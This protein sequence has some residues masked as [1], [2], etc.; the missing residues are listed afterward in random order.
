MASYH[1]ELKSDKK[2]SGVS[3]KAG[4][5]IS[6]INREGKFQNIDANT[7]LRADVHSYRSTISGTHPILPLPHQPVLLY[8]SPFGKIKLDAQGIH[9]TKNAS[10]QTVGIAFAAAQR[11]FGEELSLG[12]TEKFQEE[13][14][15]TV[16]DLNLDVH[17]T[18]RELEKKNTANR[19]EREEIERGRRDGTRGTVGHTGRDGCGGIFGRTEGSAG[20]LVR[21]LSPSSGVSKSDTH[22]PTLDEIAKKGLLLHV[23]PGGNV[24]TKGR[25]TPVFLSDDVKRQ[26]YLRGGGRETRLALRWTHAR[27][28]R[29]DVERTS[30]C[31]LGDSS[32]G[33]KQ[34]IRFLAPTVHQP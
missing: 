17:F 11:I 8:S 24:G 28:R 26:L 13:A 18:D 14:L 4:S 2:P 23:L 32:K 15:I 16:R 9:V 34:H 30:R 21:A 19:K 12:G 3:I 29:R 33:Y 5:H 22:Q 1:F 7:E 20:G 10:P 6:Y 31:H 27:A 25:R